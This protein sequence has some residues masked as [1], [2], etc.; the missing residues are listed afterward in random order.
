MKQEDERERENDDDHKPHSSST[1]SWVP[2]DHHYFTGQIA[3][4]ERKCVWIWKEINDEGELN[5]M[6]KRE[7]L[8]EMKDD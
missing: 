3:H 1:I 2:N 5:D 7:S 8:K 4:D 6:Q